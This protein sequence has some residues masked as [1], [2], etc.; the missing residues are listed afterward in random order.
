[1]SRHRTIDRE[2]LLDAAQDLIAQ[3]GLQAFSFDAVAKKCHITKG[4]VQYCFGTKDGLI[5][6]LITRWE[7]SFT[8]RF[9]DLTDGGAL[10][11]LQAYAQL[12]RDTVGGNS[13]RAPAMLAAMLRSQERLQRSQRWYQERLSDLRPLGESAIN[14]S[15]ALLFFAVEGLHLLNGFG[16]LKM[17]QAECE[18]LIDG[19]VNV[20][21][22]LE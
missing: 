2:V 12:A 11:A 21:S 22:Q 10:P 16:F 1:M 15:D 7:T 6:A 5:D 18:Q 19:M 17:S 3:E 8:E 4:G 20:H 9:A 14:A 13:A